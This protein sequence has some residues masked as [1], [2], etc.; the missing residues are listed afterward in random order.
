MQ[1]RKHIKTTYECGAGNINILHSTLSLSRMRLAR[2]W[3]WNCTL[4]LLMQAKNA[5]CAAD[6]SR[7]L[8]KLLSY[9]VF[10]IQVW[11]HISL[12][13]SLRGFP[14]LQQIAHVSMKSKVVAIRI[15]SGTRTVCIFRAYFIVWL[16]KQQQPIILWTRAR[17]MTT[18]RRI[19]VHSAK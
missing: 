3:P 18:R 10:N 2:V 1:K 15:V 5:S 4:F 17:V 19:L 6:V 13:R 7:V 12:T 11:L 9:R 14:R 16:A 8:S